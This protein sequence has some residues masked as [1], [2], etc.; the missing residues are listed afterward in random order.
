MDRETVERV[1]RTAH[2]KLTDEELERYSKDLED[3]LQYFEMLD[4]AP[5]SDVGINPIMVAD[6]LREDEPSRYPDAYRLLEGMRTYEGYVRGPR[7]L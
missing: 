2:L 3:I 1:A 6:V 4:D 7:L 5:E